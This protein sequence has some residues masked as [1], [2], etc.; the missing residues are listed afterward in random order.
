MPYIETR[1]HVSLYYRDWGT[2]A[3]IVFISSWALGGAMWE[4]QMVSLSEQGLRC[5]A[6][7]RRGHGRSDDPGRGYDFDTLADDLDAL[8]TQLD[9]HEITLVGHSMGCAEVARYL[10]RYGT[11]RV[12]RVVLASPVTPFLLETEDNPF[13]AP[14][15]VHEAHITALATDRPL[16]F[17]DGAIKFFSLGSKWPTP[18]D[19]SHEMVQWSIRL[20]LESSPQATIGFRRAMAKTDFR[21]DMPAFSVPTLIIHGD[22]DQT[23]PLEI[24]GRRTAQAIE[25]SQLKV[26]EGAPHGL[27]LTDRKRLNDDLL[28]W[29]RGEL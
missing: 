2:G 9:L 10:S 25:G 13:G 5:I 18:P 12:A 20:I 16:Y 7:D 19:L 24:C 4:Y 23:A 29:S 8:L 6:C 26:Y 17:T 11:G 21:P 1:D 22:N 28:A 14:L 15:A 3:P 27:F